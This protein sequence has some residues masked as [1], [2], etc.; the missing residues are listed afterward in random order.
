MVKKF[1]LVFKIVI[2]S[3][4]IQCTTG[5]GT[6]SNKDLDKICFMELG[7]AVAK[8]S[9]TDSTFVLC[10]K[11]VEANPNSPVPYLEYIVIKQESLKVVY[12][13][14]VL[15]GSIDWYSDEELLIKEKLG[16]LGQKSK[17]IR[18]YR[19]NIKTKHIIDV[20]QTENF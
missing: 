10:W 2:F 18:V 15:S 8:S 7:E 11:E 12:K 4:A 19:V 20:E 14:K 5:R 3:F 1:I 9:S 13:G 16:I 6:S 17:N